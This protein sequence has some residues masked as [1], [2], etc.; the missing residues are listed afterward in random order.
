MKPFTSET[1]V[2]NAAVSGG[3]SKWPSTREPTTM[4]GTSMS[5]RLKAPRPMGGMV[6]G[7]VAKPGQ[8]SCGS[9]KLPI[10]IGGVGRGG[11]GDPGQR[12]RGEPWPADLRQRELAEVDGRNGDGRDIEAGKADGRYGKSPK[13][14]GWD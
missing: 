7:A 14:K 12:R 4:L 1:S 10:P 3:I 6:S 11:G 2:L 8:L 13:G 9:V 5:G